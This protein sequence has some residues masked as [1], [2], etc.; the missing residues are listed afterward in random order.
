MDVCGENCD[1]RDIV[2]CP[3]QGLLLM[4]R[5]EWCIGVCNCQAQ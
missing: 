1:V 2:V 3:E 5:T 4:T